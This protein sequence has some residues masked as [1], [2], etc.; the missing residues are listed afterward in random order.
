[1]RLYL[2]GPITGAKDAGGWRQ[3]VLPQL[4]KGW[5]GVDPLEHERYLI[6]AGS[7]PETIVR[8]DLELIAACDAVLALTD[9]PSFGT[10]M[11]IHFAAQMAIPVLSW[12][13]KHRG[14]PTSP[15]LLAHSDMVTSS[16][17]EV[18]AWLEKRVRHA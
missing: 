1:M 6:D 8:K 12:R 14:G 7:D 18:V 11:E 4:P 15:W 16:F 9:V 17:A 2:A 10:A 13:P 3:D 5:V